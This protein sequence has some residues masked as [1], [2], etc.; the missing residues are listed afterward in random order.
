[1]YTININQIY[2]IE[3]G[4]DLLCDSE[5]CLD[6]LLDSDVVASVAI[7]LLFIASIAF[8]YK[9]GRNYKR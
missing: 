2:F 5:I 4:S 3:I 9:V 6:R 7:G 1:M 8:G